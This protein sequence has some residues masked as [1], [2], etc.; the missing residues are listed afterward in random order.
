[1]PAETQPLW[2]I[3]PAL[4]LVDLTLDVCRDLLAQS[5]PMRVLLIDQGSSEESNDRFRQFA[6]AH[7]P[8][9]LLW[10][11]TLP[12]PSLSAAWNHGLT[13]VWATGGAE[14]LVCNS[15]IR[16]HPLT[17]GMLRM[18]RKRSDALFIS[19][20]GVSTEEQ[21]KTAWAHE[22]H[23]WVPQLSPTNLGERGGPDFSCFLITAGA[24]WKYPFD[25]AFIPAFMEDLDAHRRYMLGGDG[26]RIFS[27]N[28]P[29]HH[30]GGGSRTINQSD[31]ARAK[32]ERQAGIARSHY[33]RKWGGGPNQERAVT[34]FSTLGHDGVTTPE[35]Q[36]R[37]QA[38]LGPLEGVVPAIPEDR[39]LT[40]DEEVAAVEDAFAKAAA[41]IRAAESPSPLDHGEA[42]ARELSDD[43]PF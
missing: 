35:L 4:D 25:E 28:L 21:F 36:A 17:A 43:I 26:A 9:V 7:H 32:F 8:Q 1:M 13:F 27:I 2:A 41:R 18:N 22:P 20:V 29:F 12:M 6:E 3:V 24:H 11:F 23:E 31:A 30:I 15:D 37:V 10:S 5:I 16:L 40:P 38:G 33:Q 42:N 39:E 19:A 14:A 34:P